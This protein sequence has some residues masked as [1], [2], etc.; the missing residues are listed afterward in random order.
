[1]ESHSSISKAFVIRRRILFFL[2]Y[3]FF[4]PAFFCLRAFEVLIFVLLEC[5]SVFVSSSL[6]LSL[7]LSCF[8]FLLEAMLR[9]PLDSRRRT[10]LILV[11]GVE[12]LFR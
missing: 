12:D 4:F 2:F 9:E 8:S 5:G 1:M 11:E 6:S 7:S 10:W 3:N